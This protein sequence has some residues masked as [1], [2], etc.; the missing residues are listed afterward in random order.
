MLSS[1]T[2]VCAIGGS[3]RIVSWHMMIFE[4]WRT[5]GTLKKLLGV[6]IFRTN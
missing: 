6:S 4:L 1:L 2:E 3:S 5:M